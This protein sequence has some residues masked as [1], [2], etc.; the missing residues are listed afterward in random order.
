MH[1][2]FGLVALIVLAMMSS[3]RQGRAEARERMKPF[4]TFCAF[5]TIALLA[6]FFAPYFFR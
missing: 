1:L 5:G 2:L 4:T 6:I 3:T